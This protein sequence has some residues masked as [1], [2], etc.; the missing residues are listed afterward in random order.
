MENTNKKLLTPLHYENLLTFPILYS[1][2]SYNFSITALRTTIKT[3]FFTDL[4]LNILERIYYRNESVIK[5][6]RCPTFASAPLLTILYVI[7]VRSEK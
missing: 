6:P 7:G 3:F 1:K 5:Q 2:V 4:F